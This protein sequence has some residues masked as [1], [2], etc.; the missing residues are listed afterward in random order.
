MTY[1]PNAPIDLTET[2]IR[3][4]VDG[5][6]IEMPARAILRLLPNPRLV[7]ECV[8]GLSEEYMQLDFTQSHIT[9]SLFDTKTEFIIGQGGFTFGKASKVEVT[10]SPKYEPVSI[11]RTGKRI[12]S[13]EFGILNFPNFLQGQD[14]KV[15]VGEQWRIIGSV[16]LRTDGWEIE[17]AAVTA[18]SDIEKRLKEEGGYAITHTGA[19]RRVDGSD[20]TAQDVEP[21]LSA[22]RLFLSF[23]RGT[24]CGL[25]LVVGKDCDGESVWEQWGTHR[26]TEWSDP[27]P[28]WFDKMSGDSLAE[29]FPGFWRL[30]Q[31]FKQNDRTRLAFE[32][33][34][35]SNSQRALHSSIVLS[36]AALERLT[37]VHVGKKLT[38]KQLGR[39]NGE[40]EGEWIARALNKIGV[41]CKIPPSCA[42]LEKL[43]SDNGFAHGPHTLVKIRNDLIH[44][45]MSY[46]I[47]SVDVYQQ[48]RKLG[49]WYTE[50][51][52]LKLAKFNGMYG[53]R[54]TQQWR[55]Q[56]EPVPWAQV[57]PGS[58]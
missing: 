32:W 48:A 57:G 14:K 51:M 9:A 46:D 47:L 56:V 42:A 10:L 45:D 50:L 13:L 3:F 52:L 58:S 4:D 33:Y 34:L 11:Y 44:Q 25:A 2:V 36:Q 24:Y 22:L 18:A 8:E 21:L 31:G 40:T 35:E 38:K 15:V 7:I 6:Q 12:S 5:A 49:L 1:E 26:V 37:F 39:K 29:A 41:G 16:L 27:P 19:V 23:A 17:I 53:N 43:R 55:G 20:F 30:W 54:M 28:S